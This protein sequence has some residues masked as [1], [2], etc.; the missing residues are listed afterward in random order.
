MR[1]LAL[2]ASLSWAEAP[3]SLLPVVDDLALRLAGRDKAQLEGKSGGEAEL[4]CRDWAEGL[5]LCFTVAEGDLRR[6]VSSADLQRWG[7]GLSQVEAAASAAVAAGMSQERPQQVPVGGD[8]RTYLLSAE[9]D[10]LDQAALFQPQLLAERLGGGRVAVGIPAK[11]VLIAFSLGDQELETIVAVGIRRAF[12]TLSDPIT[13]AVYTW[14]G[15]KWV[16]WGEAKPQ[17]PAQGVEP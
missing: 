5:A 9:G 7:V 16:V 6:M 14:N 15:I 17:A 12:E 2:A 8:T 11:G 3:A 1:W 13:P 4:A 10:G